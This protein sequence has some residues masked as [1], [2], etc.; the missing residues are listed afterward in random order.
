MT[1]TFPYARAQGHRVVLASRASNPLA[2]AKKN[3][4]VTHSVTQYDKQQ[5][6]N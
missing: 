2:H 4:Q 6:T 5:T 1:E 3:P